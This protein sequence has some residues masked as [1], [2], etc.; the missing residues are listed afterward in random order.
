MNR[1][2]RIA[3]REYVAYIRTIGF[4]L[5]MILMPVGL[6]VAAGAPMLLERSAPVPTLAVIDLSGQD[7]A[8]TI[9]PRLEAV[10]PSGKPEL[11]WA[12]GM[13]GNDVRR[14]MKLVE[15]RQEEFVVRWREIHG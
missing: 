12:Y 13:N 9:R 11:V 7:F 3:W 14:A 5:S 4:W 15:G 2:L 10:G 8:R 1:L 6:F